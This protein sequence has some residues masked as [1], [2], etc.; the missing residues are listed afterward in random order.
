MIID[1]LHVVSICSDPAEADAPLFIDAD[2]VLAPPIAGELLKAIGG[3]NPE[4]S[5]ASRGI[6]HS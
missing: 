5:E 4:V 2:T 1:D 3:R 6:E